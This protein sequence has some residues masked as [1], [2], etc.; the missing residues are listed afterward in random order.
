MPDF[1]DTLAQRV[2]RRLAAGAVRDIPACKKYRCGRQPRAQVQ[3]VQRTIRPHALH[4]KGV[5]IA[6]P[7]VVGGNTL[8]FAAYVGAAQVIVFFSPM[9]HKTMTG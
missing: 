5:G 6:D 4:I 3:A 1:K 7:E 9:R 2:Q 8:V